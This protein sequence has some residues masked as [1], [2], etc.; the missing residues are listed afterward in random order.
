MPPVFADASAVINMSREDLEKFVMKATKLIEMDGS[1][2]ATAQSSVP[3]I[4]FQRLVHQMARDREEFAEKTAEYDRNLA[5]IKG[6]LEEERISAKRK[7][8]QYETSQNELRRLLAEG[9]A[10]EENL[11]Q[12]LEMSTIERRQMTQQHDEDKAAIQDTMLNV[13][14]RYG[15]VCKSLTDLATVRMQLQREADDLGCRSRR[16]TSL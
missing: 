2:Q 8:R 3:Y 14:A 1:A 7:A 5:R 10:R 16:R 6:K 11:I 9:K 13:R 15:A 12:E 4:L